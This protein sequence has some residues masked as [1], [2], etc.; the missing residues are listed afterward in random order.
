MLVPFMSFDIS[1]TAFWDFGP[2]SRYAEDGL[3][4]GLSVESV[5]VFTL[6]L[7]A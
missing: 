2:V 3:R 6:V 1:L 7:D 4:T 5:S